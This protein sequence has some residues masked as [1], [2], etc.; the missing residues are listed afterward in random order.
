MKPLPITWKRLVKDGETCLRCGSTQQTVVGAIATLEAALRPLGIQPELE[1]AAIDEAAF[2]ADPSQ[3]NRI[4]IAG[5]PME[6]WL[7]ARVGSSPCR[8]VCGDLPC[9][10]VE[11]G[12]ATYEAIPEALIVRAGM[13]AAAG[14]IDR[15]A[16]LAPSS[17]CCTRKC[18]C[19]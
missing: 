17:A 13:I 5:K 9:R 12:G 15:A 2:R 1:T 4:W 7:G 14:M 8:S 6:E 3:S 16:E 10:T 11:V 18:H 19:H